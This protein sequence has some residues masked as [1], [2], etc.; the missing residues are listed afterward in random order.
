ML[1][2]KNLGSHY[3]KV[4]KSRGY[5]LGD[6]SSDYLNKSQLSRFENG[7]QMLLVDGFMHAIKGLNMTISEFFLTIGNFEAGSLHTFGEKLQELINNQ[8]IEGLN[9]L[10]IRNPR[11]NEKKIFNIKVKCAIRELSGR[12][13]ITDEER[14]FIDGYLT[15]REEWTAFDIDVF[16][17]C[18]ESLDSELVFQLGMQLVKKD[19]FRMLPYN[20]HIAKRTLVNI[21]VYMVL[22]GRFLYAEKI[23][24]ELNI[25]LNSMDTEERIAIYIF[26]KI[27]KFRKENTPELYV[28]IKKDILNLEQ[29]GGVGLSRI[30][31]T[32]WLTSI[33]N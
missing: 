30:I 31:E 14:H 32:F 15:N 7:T 3:Q 26:K 24:S 28:E 20:D 11:T 29:L 23:E 17:M 12:S 27:A 1:N 22:H 13:L 33:K 9:E 6:I 4:R 16:G 5:T 21:Y 10:I 19:K 8:N 2:F 25:L 18:L